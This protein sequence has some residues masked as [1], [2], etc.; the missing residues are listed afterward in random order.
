MILWLV[1]GVFG[2]S[3]RWFSGGFY[4]EIMRDR[5]KHIIIFFS[6]HTVIHVSIVSQAT[7][8]YFEKIK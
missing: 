4:R 6:N 5:A 2:V 3:R 8:I 1:S 7:I